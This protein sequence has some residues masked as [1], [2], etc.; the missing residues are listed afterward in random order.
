MV[1]VFRPKFPSLW[2]QMFPVEQ[3]RLATRLIERVVI[4]EDGLEIIWRDQGWQALAGELMPGTIGAELQE[5]E[6]MVE[7]A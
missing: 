2:R 7:A 3:S 1:Y 6:Q 4:A 5:L